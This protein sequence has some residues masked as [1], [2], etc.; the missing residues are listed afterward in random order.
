MSRRSN[1]SVKDVAVLAGVSLGTVSNV[2]NAPDRVRP[3]TRRRVEEAITKLGWV[4][5]ESARQLR[6]GKSTSV[7]MV[8]MDIANPFFTD[9]VGG[10]EAALGSRGFAVQLGNSG[11]LKARESGHLRVFAEHQVR[12]VLVAPIGP[13]GDQIANLQRR[14]TPVVVVDRAAE[15]MDC[16]SV[17]VD[18]VTGGRLAVTHLIEQGH[19]RIA[20][21]GGRSRLQQVRDRRLGAHLASSQAGQSIELLVISTPELDSAGGVRA[22][23]DIATLPDAVRPTAVFA[24][25]DLVAIGLLQG[26]VTLG[27]RVP[28]DIA[29]IGYD[30]VSF[31]E[32]A[33][34]PLSSI[35]QPRHLLGQR[36]A[37]LLLEEI[38]ALDD[39]V[40]HAHRHE[41]F[42][43]E[44]VIRRSTLH[45]G[46]VGSTS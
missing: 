23:E 5:N 14:G 28:E 40:P 39:G 32:S 45:R 21:A 35:R 42:P 4:R 27:L 38:D 12:G 34:V 25:N 9:V 10:V 36:A 3:D 46:R 18:D 24:V 16:C 29:I 19:R 7:G 37:E 13:I 26:F 15:G 44:L 33:A 11:G 20:C 8:V 22:A 17:T 31:A 43:P 2:L 41:V 6:A 30:D 1:V